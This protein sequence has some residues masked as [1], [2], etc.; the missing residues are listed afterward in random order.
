MPLCETCAEEVQDNYTINTGDLYICGQ[1]MVERSMGNVVEFTFRNV[2]EF[3]E[4][5][6]GKDGQ[7]D[8]VIPVA[9]MFSFE[10]SLDEITP[11]LFAVG[12]SQ[13]WLSVPA[14]CSI[15]FQKRLCT[16]VWNVKFEHNFPCGSKSLDLWMWRAAV[17]SEFTIGFTTGGGS[18]VSVPITFTAL[19]CES[20]HPGAPFGEAVFNVAC[21]QT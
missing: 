21:P 18:A 10:I 8:A 5:K 1:E 3:I 19:P 14:G 2:P 6:R 20:L 7:L 12:L 15:P 16:K 9:E 11:L 13:D 17:Y 4:H